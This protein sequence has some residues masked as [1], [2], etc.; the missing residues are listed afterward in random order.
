MSARAD[1]EGRWR[2]RAGSEVP[3]CAGAQAKSVFRDAPERGGVLNVGS[4]RAHSRPPAPRAVSR[5]FLRTDPW[6][7][8]PQG[9]GCEP[10][11]GSFN[12][13]L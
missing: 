8:N 12:P 4:L 3:E 7:Y 2:I 10:D 9:T 5:A 6:S 13:K 1:Q 11:R